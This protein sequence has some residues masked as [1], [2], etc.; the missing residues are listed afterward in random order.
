[1]STTSPTAAD[2]RV[3]PVPRAV[4]G[5]VLFSCWLAIL[6]DG[7]DIGVIGA[8]LPALAEDSAWALS[9]VELGG[10]AS[11]A[12]VGMLIGA[13]F[14]GTLS[15]RVGRKRMLL[16][17][18]SIFT[19][20]QLGA[21]LAPTPELFGLFRFLGGLGMGGIIPVAAALTIEFSAPRRRAR[22][23]GL[24]YSGYSLGIVV[25][26]VVAM[27]LL[28]HL[29]WRWVIAVG[30][31]PILLIPIIAKVLPESLESLE[32]RGRHARAA[33]LAERLGIRPYVPTIRPQTTPGHR[34]P[35]QRILHR[36]FSPPYLRSTVFLW[37]SLFAGLLLVYGLNSWLPSIMRAAGYDLGPALA[38]LLVFSLASA[39]GGLVLGHLADRFGS[40]PILIVFYTVGG[41]A[42]L[43][44]MFPNT[45]LLNLVLVGLSGVG[46]I[47]TSLVL[48]AYITDYY[49]ASVR[50]TAA[51][52]ALSFARI[53]AIMGPMLGGWLASLAVAAAWNFVAFAIVAIVAAIAVAL[54]PKKPVTVE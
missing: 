24:M 35:W 21:A 50:A 39:V 38:F 17:S 14:I 40:K 51:G 26:A 18:M 30:A 20:M 44:L 9:P 6:A 19:L 27:A 12:L 43:L 4:T 15:D 49:P 36:L 48:T 3:W 45:M 16:V 13:L 46:S 8:V 37:I 2:E 54:V 33:A 23:Y 25:S 47:S 52:W 41:L 29:G 5:V 32:N 53:G 28:P 42:C 31:F 7:Y 10:L 1:M 22:N 34:L 11:W